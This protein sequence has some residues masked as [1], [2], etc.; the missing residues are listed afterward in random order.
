MIILYVG[1]DFLFDDYRKQNKDVTFVLKSN[2]L[3]AFKELQYNRSIDAVIS[4]YDLPGN[5]GLFF[6]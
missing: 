2:G 4:Q 3:E 1:G 6:F 5:Y